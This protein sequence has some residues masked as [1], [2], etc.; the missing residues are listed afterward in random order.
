MNKSRPTTIERTSKKWKLWKALSGLV[1]FVGMAIV[2]KG[3]FGDGKN[4]N[5][6]FMFGGGIVCGIAFLSLMIASTL[7]W[8]ENG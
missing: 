6:S 7:A 3:V 2:A 1:M 8:W 4:P 5:F